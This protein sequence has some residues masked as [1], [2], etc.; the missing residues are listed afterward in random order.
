MSDPN[1]ILYVVFLVAIALC[2][3]AVTSKFDRDRIRENI[4]EH[5]G[6]VIEISRVWWW[7]GSRYDRCYDVTYLTA[8]G[9]RVCATCRTSMWRGVYWVNDRP[10]GL[11]SDEGAPDELLLDY[12]ARE[13]SVAA[14]PIQ[15]LGCGAT[16]PARKATCPQCGWSYQAYQAGK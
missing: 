7:S 12:D 1:S 16:I 10:P 15:C 13:S 14:E 3:F 5:G 11:F 6:K 2:A 9:R 4:E 8:R